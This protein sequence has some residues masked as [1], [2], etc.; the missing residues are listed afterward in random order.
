LDLSSEPIL[1]SFQKFQAI[2]GTHLSAIISGVQ[3]KDI[4]LYPGL[5]RRT[6]IQ[7]MWFICHLYINHLLYFIFYRLIFHPQHA[8]SLAM[9]SPAFICMGQL[10]AYR[11]EVRFDGKALYQ[12]FGEFRIRLL[13]SWDAQLREVKMSEVG[14]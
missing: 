7:Y 2:S 3:M 8:S 12:K 13:V 4:V 10:C 11:L 9:G 5:Q 1:Q 6:W 14:C